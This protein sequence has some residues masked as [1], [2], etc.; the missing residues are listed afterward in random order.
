MKNNSVISIR[1]GQI[2]LNL[3]FTLLTYFVSAGINFFLSPY[4]VLQL[5]VEAHGFVG[6]A[7]NIVSYISL[8]TVALNSVASRF[9]SLEYYRENH[10]EASRYYSAVFWGNLITTFII[11]IPSIIF[12]YKLENLIE[13]PVKLVSD[14]K[15]L[16]LLL[17][18]NFCLTTLT[19]LWNVSTFI[20]NK[21]F[22]N[23]TRD[24][25]SMFVKLLLL[26]YLFTTYEP[27]IYYVGLA[28]LISTAISSVITYVY[29]IK[30]VAELKVSKNGNILSVIYI[31]F[32][33]GVWNVINSL[34]VLL[35]NGVDLLIANVYLE[36]LQMGYL[37]LSKTIP[38]VLL[39][40]TGLLPSVFMP[41][42]INKYAKNDIAHLIRYVNLSNRVSSLIM[43][44][45]LFGFVSFGFEFYQLWVPGQ[46][47]HLLHLLSI[48]SLLPSLLTGGI[49]SIY[50]IFTVTNQLRLNAI[51]VISSGVISL[52]LSLV[53]IQGNSYGVYLIVGIS[54]MITIVRQ[55]LFSIPYAAKCLGLNWSYFF[56]ELRYMLL[57]GI[58][59]MLVSRV[60]K[61]I[62]IPHSWSTFTIEIALVALISYIS[63]SFLLLSKSERKH[64][65]QL[66]Y[67]KLRG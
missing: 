52:V 34:G 2:G 5:G 60:T 67:S 57:G 19:N 23:S 20:T 51:M 17:I 56:K 47:A 43:A 13:V 32:S 55:L 38:F 61:L 26:L 44:V 25:A 3:L 45:P 42:F 10:T 50:N 11:I 31:L 36:P 28:Q 41:T 16:M 22:L 29:K 39:T 18:I 46:D 65:V 21:L 12:I 7:N 30:L 27:H 59:T 54:S 4:I 14:V 62:Y 63:A 8:S 1:N 66:V 40:L 35:L 6:L 53:L 48:F 64:I 9:I 24:L 15:T 49:Q 58:L 33:S 37:S